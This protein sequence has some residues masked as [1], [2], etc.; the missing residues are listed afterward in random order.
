M[1]VDLAEKLFVCIIMIVTAVGVRFCCRRMGPSGSWASLFIFPLLFH[2]P[3]IMGFMNYSFALGLML[4]CFGFWLRAETDSLWWWLAFAL[5]VP[6]LTLSHPVPLLMLLLLCGYD[7]LT[8]RIFG[9]GKQSIAA[10]SAHA[11]DA[12]TWISD[13]CPCLSTAL[14]GPFAQQP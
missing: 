10:P 2:W 12:C 9:G 8:A 14:F 6:L 11:A 3:L 13:V 4:L 7:F 5:T 1:D